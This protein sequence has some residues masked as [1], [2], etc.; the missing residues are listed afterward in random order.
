[1]RAGKLFHP[2]T[3]QEQTATADSYGGNIIAWST[4][5][6]SR[7]GIWPVKGIE[8]VI[9]GKL[10]MVTRFIISMRYISGVTAGMCILK[11]SDSRTFEILSVKN[12]DEKN[13]QIDL[14]C[15]EYV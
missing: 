2:I 14:L 13:K 8:T 12:V 3:I 15:K 6:K 4:H 1:M 7:A 11:N 9:D 10:T 5:A